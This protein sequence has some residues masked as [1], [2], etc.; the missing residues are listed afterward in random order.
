MALGGKGVGKSTFLKYLTNRVLSESDGR[1]VLFVDLDPGQAE[2]T[3]PGKKTKSKTFVPKY[4]DKKKTIYIYKFYCSDVSVE[5]L[6]K[7]L[8]FF[9]Q[10]VFLPQ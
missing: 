6:S 1:P 3:I 7:N 10:D 5:V 8:Y 9:F 4:F 2:F